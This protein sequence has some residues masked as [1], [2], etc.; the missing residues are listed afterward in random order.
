MCGTMAMTSCEKSTKLHDTNTDHNTC[1]NDRPG[2][3]WSP[4]VNLLIIAAELGAH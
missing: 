3:Q 1:H 4:V 2:S